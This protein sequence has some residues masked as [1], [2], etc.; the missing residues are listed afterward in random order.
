MDVIDGH[1][2]TLTNSIEPGNYTIVATYMG[3]SVFN[4]NTTSGDVEILGHIL[5]DT[6]ITA[7]VTTNGNRV[8]LTVEVDE[9]ATGFVQLLFGDNEFNIALEDGI[10]KLT[11][12]LP[13]GSYSLDII[14]LGDENYNMNYTTCDFTIAESAKE[15][16]PI[17][18]DIVTDETY[19]G[20]TVTV[21]EA[22][23]GLVKFQVTGEEDYVVY[24]DVINGVAILE[25]VLT[26]GNYSVTAT[27]MGDSVF[28]TNITSAD[29]TIKGHIKKDTPISARADVVGSRVTI[30]VNVNENA[31]GF[32]KLAVGGTVANIEVEDGVAKLT[33]ILVP[34][35]YL[36]DVTYLGDDDYNMNNTKVTFTITEVSKEDT[37]ISLDVETDENNVTFTAEVDSRATGIV[38]FEVTGDAELS[39]YVDVIEG[40]AVF[41]NVLNGGSYTVIAT[42][43]G[44]SVFNTNVTSQGFTVKD[45]KPDANV[46]VNVPSDIKAG[47]DVPISVDIPGATGNVS[48]IVDGVE[49][50]VPLVDGKVNYTIPG[51]DV[52][53]H[54]IVVAYPGDDTYAA[55]NVTKLINV[56]AISS[57][58]K[59]ITLSGSG[60]ITVVLVDETGA[61]IANADLTYT[62]NGNAS[63]AKTNANGIV[64]INAS[65][66]TVVELKYAGSSTIL[67][68]NTTITIKDLAPVRGSTVINGNDYTQ[69][70]ID[71]YYGERG[72][73]FTVQL[74]DANGKPLANKTVLIGYNG[75]ILSRTTDEN[76][77]ARVQINLVQANRLTFA[78]TFLDDEEYNATM[79]VYLITIV[80]KPITISAS[81]ASYKASAKTKKYTISL[82]TI[83]G[84]SAD[85]K[86]Y[87][88]QGKKVTMQINGKTYTAKVDK[89][90]KAT[91]NLQIT[92]KGVYQASIK[93]AGD[94]TYASASRSVKITIK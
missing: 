22:A 15:N 42:Y 30:T 94:D 8:T 66:N 35:S 63:E 69:Y 24:S 50:A 45:Q 74:V 7:N 23:T 56:R 32:V 58:F 80:K 10:G 4:T 31:T 6:P 3:D 71:Y 27:Y 54:T 65:A 34:N 20:M 33:T 59:D 53:E 36:V 40:K 51:M 70:A 64:E 67:P 84:A 77:Y 87:Y 48:I 88:P 55:T 5:K 28:N 81:A 85:G 49:T 57:E 46:T 47:E 86:I 62:I 37:P 12:S 19:V 73:N 18:L 60:L 90:G 39:V 38:K 2:E 76:G 93:Y 44:D 17:S 68:A 26:V 41:E 11:T 78:V 83:K 13:Y 43:M 91:F 29:F 21:D 16:T 9:N 72:Q 1:V 25:D 52:G 79:S 82:K 61:P 14:Y 92:K 89:N 75:K